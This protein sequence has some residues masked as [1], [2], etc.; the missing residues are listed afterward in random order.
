MDKELLIFL[1]NELP[2]Y[3]SLF[4]P[5]YLTIYLYFFFCGKSFKD[6]SWIIAKTIF[7]SYFYNVIC[8]NI[9]ERMGHYSEINMNITLVI[10]AVVIGIVAAKIKD[11]TGFG[12]ILNHIKNDTVFLDD[13]FEILRNEDRSAW[14]C[15]YIKNSNIVYEGSLREVNLDTDKNEKYVCLSGYYKY[16]IDGNGKPIEPYIMNVVNDNEEKVVIHYSDIG[17][18]EKRNTN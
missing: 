16:M 18:I 1:L 7:I 6:S 14:I 13:E 4:Y 5:G 3:I 11:S 15:I 17:V 9:L 8:K 2:K 12:K 10:L